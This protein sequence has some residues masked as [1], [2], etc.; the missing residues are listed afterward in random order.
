MPSYI[1]DLLWN[2]R[3]I[4][5]VIVAIYLRSDTESEVRDNTGLPVDLYYIA[6]TG[7]METCTCQDQW[8]MFGFNKAQYSEVG[9][10]VG[11]LEKSL[12][13]ANWPIF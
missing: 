8:T 2:N 3:D 5:H 13:S 10:F 9:I 7:R 6:L 4:T 12:Y 11:F 1:A